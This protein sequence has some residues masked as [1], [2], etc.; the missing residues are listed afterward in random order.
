MSSSTLKGGRVRMPGARRPGPEK[1]PLVTGAPRRKLGWVW[2]GVG[3]VAVS[4][5]GFTLAAQA[6]GDRESVLV[7]ARD[8]PVGQ[9]LKPKHLRVV[10]VA[11]DTGVV[12]LSDRNTVLG[13]RAS[14]PLTAGALLAPGQ[15]GTRAVFP[16]EG[17]S[18]VAL[19]V[20]PGGAPPE[21]AAGERV[22]VL[23]GPAGVE[24]VVEEEETS[25]AVVG[26]VTDVREPESAGGPR[27]VTVL[28]ETGAARRATQLEHPRVVVLPAQGRETP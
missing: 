23:P 11:A 1:S 6:V 7:L 9:V 22:A 26:T 18:Q 4:A 15:V 28:V 13:R 24:A 10:D 2:A 19:A 20:E 17:F 5:V 25:S 27:V 14:V 21:L 16:A 12:P 8:V 3:A